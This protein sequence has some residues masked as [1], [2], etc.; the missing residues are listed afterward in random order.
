MHEQNK[1]AEAE[2]FLGRMR[3]TQNDPQ[4]FDFN[5]SAFL[6]ASRSVLQYAREDAKAKGSQVW[7]DEAIRAA[8][9]SVAFLGEKRNISIHSQPVRPARHIHVELHDRLSLTAE[10]STVVIR[11]DGSREEEVVQSG[12][13]DRPQA[14]MPDQPPVVTFAHRFADW[15]GP[16]DVLTLAGRYLEA[17]QRIVRDGL[18]RGVLSE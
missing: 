9:P 10:L 5:L 16:E 8:D 12:A 7:Y 6:A 15:T 18:D 17:L 3:E 14:P 2:Y 11:R 4:A 1:L 13:A